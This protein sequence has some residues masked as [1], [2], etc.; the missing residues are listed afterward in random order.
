MAAGLAL[1]L[2]GGCVE[3]R[4]E[5]YVQGVIAPRA[6]TNST[7]CDYDPGPGCSLVRGHGTLDIAFRD[8]Y[9][10]RLLVVSQLAPRA[11][12]T[13]LRVESSH[14]YLQG[15][16][17]R[18]TDEAGI[19]L[20]N[21]E[22]LATGFVGAAGTGAV[23]VTMVD[24]KTVQRLRPALTSRCPRKTVV[25]YVKLRG[26]T[27]GGVR[28]EAGEFQLAVDLCNGCLVRFPREAIDES[29]PV[30]PNCLAASG[31]SHL[32]APCEFGQ[33]EEIDCRLCAADPVCQPDSCVR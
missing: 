8:T 2:G 21:Y 26:Q 14:M 19:E 28:V 20:T 7:S 25:S 9:R 16:T 11:N 3:S 27:L 6:R 22:T 18:I 17:I 15:A 33:D 13:Q 24:A 29:R 4:A 30:V 12:A 1:M 23:T 5:L 31:S 10:P 32:S